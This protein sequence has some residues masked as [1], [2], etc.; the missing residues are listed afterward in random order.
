[1]KTAIIG[2]GSIGLYYGAKLMA[3]G[4][5]V[6]FL[7]RSGFDVA[8]QDGIRVKSQDGDMHIKSPAVAR[9]VEEIG[10]SDLVIIS[11]KVTDNAVLRT[12]LP[13]LLKSDTALL[14]L[15]NGLGNE[16]FLAE[17]FGKDRVLGGLCFVC[18]TRDTP[19]SV[20]HFG[21]GTLSLGEFAAPGISPRLMDVAE[22]F[23]RSGVET[24]TVE[25]LIAERWR[26]LVWNIPFNGLSV[27]SGGKTVD[28]ILESPELYQSCVAL[29]HEV[30]AVANILGY[31]IPLDFADVQLA[32]TYPMGAYQPSTLVDFLARKPLEIEAIWGEPLRR[33]HVAGVP[34]PHLEALYERL[35]A[36]V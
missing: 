1:M 6:R 11:L 10:S 32:R 34:V 29:M 35:R 25:N 7:M 22:R 21:H 26:K 36:C 27:A 23:R 30:I 16:D 13:P 18:L 4:E 20:E 8:R 24:H 12:L 33:A 31:A 19:A 3:S 15:Q 2:S 17:H 9:N 28:Q 14:T 5:D